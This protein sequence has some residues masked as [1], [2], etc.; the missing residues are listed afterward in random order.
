M[1][2]WLERYPRENADL[3]LK[4]FSPVPES[5]LAEYTRLLVRYLKDMPTERESKDPYEVTV[6][7]I[8]RDF[9]WRRK[10]KMHIYTYALFDSDGTMIGHSNALINGAD[11]TDVYQAMTGI[12]RDYRGRGLS[13]WLKAALFFNAL[14]Q[15]V[16]DDT[17]K[18]ILREYVNRFRWGI[19]TPDGFLEVAE[20][21]SGRDLDP[22]FN[23]WILG[24]Q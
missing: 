7:E 13:R 3:R 5:H 23:R 10:N 19:A 8:R 15:D 17:F 1:R 24:K 22:L 2:S 12:S 18:A 14:H 21:V 20:S 9:E 6:D 16:G 11:P 4:F